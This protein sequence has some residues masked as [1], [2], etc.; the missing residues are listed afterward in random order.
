MSGNA[1][2]DLWRIRK[3]L[4]CKISYLEKCSVVFYQFKTVRP[5]TIQTLFNPSPAEPGYTLPLQ[6]V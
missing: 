5:D 6:T 4:T 3:I 1:A 2:L